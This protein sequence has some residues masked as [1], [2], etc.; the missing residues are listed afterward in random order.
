M[1]I[2]TLSR[3]GDAGLKGEDRLKKD[4]R[5]DR[6]VIPTSLVG[7]TTQSWKRALFS[8]CALALCLI[9]CGCGGGGGGA[10]LPVATSTRLLQVGDQWVYQVSGQQTPANGTA[11]NVTGTL[12]VEVVQRAINGRDGLALARTVELRTGTG[13]QLHSFELSF[14]RQD[15][16]SHTIKG[17]A[18]QHDA[19]AVRLSMDNPLP[20]VVPG[21]WSDTTALSYTLDFADGSTDAHTLAVTGSEVV[22]T[23]VAPF[24]A[25]KTAVTGADSTN[26]TSSGTD[27]WAPQIGAPV[28][29]STV[30]ISPDGTRLSL[31]ATLASANT[32]GS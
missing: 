23:P 3:R 27:W 26:G 17:F 15:P 12:T 2:R 4:L 20:I 13:G 14:F 16:D 29:S 32:P 11:Q 5:R 30:H 6:A 28:K 9:M 8:L 31:A 1:S 19:A 22:P 21:H 10:A 7:M 24:T 25:W 18:D